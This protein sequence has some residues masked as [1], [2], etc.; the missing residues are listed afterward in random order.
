VASRHSSRAAT[1]ADPLLALR[2][3]TA[4]E[5]HVKRCEGGSPK[6]R[7]G[8]TARGTVE[9]MCCSSAGVKGIAAAA[10]LSSGSRVQ[11]LLERILFLSQ[12]VPQKYFVL[13]S[14]SQGWPQLYA[15]TGR[16]CCCT[17]TEG[18]AS[19]RKKWGCVHSPQSSK[20]AKSQCSQNET[21]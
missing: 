1:S 11:R 15:V 13:R 2:Y 21:R 16:H 10:T 9:G 20:V 19:K 8:K 6:P 7:F 14:H 18:R 4:R 5:R 3:T 17:T 12:P